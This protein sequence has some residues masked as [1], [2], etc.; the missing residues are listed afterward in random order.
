[1]S[2]LK[3]HDLGI[4]ILCCVGVML[5]LG[6][7]Y[8]DA[9]GF[10]AQPVTSW[11]AALPAAV[12]WFCLSGA[13]LLSAGTG[14][15]LCTKKLSAGYFKI[16]IRLVYVYLVC[17]LF[18]FAMRLVILGAPLTF[19]DVMQSI[20]RFSATETGR[21]AGM[22]FA[23]LLAAPYLNAAFE[24]LDGKNARLSLV[25]LLVLVSGLQPMLC[26]SGN[27]LL[28]EWCKGLFPVAAYFGGAYVRRYPGRRRMYLY[29]P[30]LLVILM[31]ET[32]V[33][34]LVSLPGGVMYCPWL[35]SMAGV[36][37]QGIALLLLAMFHSKKPGDS[38]VHY[39][40]AGAAGGALGALLLGDIVIDAALPAVV[41]R[42]PDVNGQ[43]IAGLAVVPVV[44]VLGCVISLVLQTPLLGLRAYLR[45]GEEEYEDEEEVRVQPQGRK[46]PDVVVPEHTHTEPAEGAS[47][48]RHTIRVPVGA[49]KT[50]INL[51]QPSPE[52]SQ[53]GSETH[54]PDVP[55]PMPEEI[56]DDA[57]AGTKVYVPKHAV[58]H[59][60]P[61][62]STRKSSTLSSAVASAAE[63]AA[64][65]EKMTVDDILIA[66]RRERRKQSE[67]S[68]VSGR[69]N[70]FSD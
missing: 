13:A 36:A 8:I 48:A 39:F 40:F 68:N 9:V 49:P 25:L 55:A 12:R 61:R 30:L 16:L 17:S 38:S 52:V 53:H 15:V 4:D 26:Q 66:E 19:A 56:S 6:L 18:G 37:S 35:D 7:Q 1:M 65:R 11:A 44:F 32:A 20:L 67:I 22:Y 70:R 24:G 2:E 34:M 21:F 29:L 28:P 45:S 64:R 51:T 5:L 50:P 59:D 41:E 42:F 10:M 54:L 62:P 63:A 57:E 58:S 27:Y 46:R 69:K 33:V 43:L 23:V 3:K 60:A 31:L 47:G 14:Y